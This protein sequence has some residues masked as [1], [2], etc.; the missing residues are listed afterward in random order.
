MNCSV[1]NERNGRE[2]TVRMRP[3]TFV[4]Q[5]G[6]GMNIDYSMMQENEGI[7]ILDEMRWKRLS[8]MYFSHRKL[9]RI[10]QRFYFSEIRI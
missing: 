1:E 3:H 7:W 2:T 6:I 8:N 9:L 5:I 10:E 4:S